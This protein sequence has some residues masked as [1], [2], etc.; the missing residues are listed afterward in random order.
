MQE[1]LPFSLGE[2]FHQELLRERR[3]EDFLAHASSHMTGSLR[4]AQLD[5]AGAPRK[6]NPLLSE[7]TL[8]TGTLWHEWF[9]RTLRDLGVPYMA[10]VNMTPWLP[11]GWAG[12]LDALVWHPELKAFVLVDFKTT[13][14]EGLKFIRRDG[15]KAEHIAQ[16]SAYWHAARKMGVP[17][18]KAVGILYWPKN[19]TRSKDELIEPLLVDFEPLPAKALHSDMKKRWGRISEYVTSLGGEPGHPVN[20]QP[21]E[22]W[23][24]DALEPV[25]EREQRIYYD[26]QLGHYD[27]KLVPSWTAAYCKFPEELCDCGTQTTTKIGMFDIDG[28]YLPRKGYEHIEPVVAPPS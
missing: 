28:E 26:R 9:H 7:I 3:P 4:H 24:T 13:K 10:E 5:V 18:A 16:T 17:L 22:G 27:V 23:V 15:A 21:L 1:I 8:K 25:Q 14:G 19:D 2:M 11:E 12:T 6:F 20:V